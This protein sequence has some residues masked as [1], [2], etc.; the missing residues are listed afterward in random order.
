MTMQWIRLAAGAAALA[1][2]AGCASVAPS[3]EEE[4]AAA[5]PPSVEDRPVPSDT[6]D[7]SSATTSPLPGRGDVTGDPLQDDPE[8]AS[9]TRVLYFDFDSSEIHPDDRVLVEAHAQYLAG[10][11]DVQLILEGHADERGS[12]EYN[13]ALAERRAVVVRDMLRL[14]GAPDDRVSA[15]SYG[16][17]RPI[18]L[19]NDEESW[20]LNR[21]VE[22]NYV[23]R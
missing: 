22:F 10:R 20:A 21:R 1:W 14:L 15:V 7:P 9:L 11:S 23:S 3:G 18:A 4:E 8:G 13:V 16:E 5:V 2:L 12:R 19:G 6:A 17:E